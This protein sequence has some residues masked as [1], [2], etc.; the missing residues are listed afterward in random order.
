MDRRAF[1]TTTAGVMAGRLAYGAS[2]RAAHQRTD[3]TRT[4]AGR[5][6]VTVGGRRVRTIDFHAHCLIPGAMELVGEK[7]RTGALI[8]GADRIRVMDE[9]GIDVEVLSINP[10]WYAADAD[11]ARRLIA[12][13]NEKLAELCAASSDRF[14]ALATVAL[15]HPLDA[16]RQLEHA[17][18]RLGLSGGSIGAS[19]N[20]L[21]L[22]SPTFDPFWAKAEELNVPVFIHPQGAPEL[23][24]RLA[25]NGHLANVIGNPL[26][27]TIALSH[28]IFEGTLDRFPGLTLCAAHGGGYLPSYAGRSDAGC[29][30]APDRCTRTIKKRPTDYLKQIV[31]DSLVFTAEGLRHLIAQC[32]VS[33]I[34]LGTDYP[35]PW[36]STAVDHVLGT[37]DLSDADREAILG[38]NAARLLK[39]T[40]TGSR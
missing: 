36:T 40:G 25:G 35:Y 20:G 1:L 38:G 17:V 3:A 18:T 14:V 33:Q 15:Q 23:D 9:Q 19:V 28:L 34:V 11:T 16:A 10:F 31:V 29:T 21:E 27:T 5:R 32:G 30:A 39:L 8:L 26:D 22:S 24:K 6:K 7:T 4:A 2:G 37:P 13:Q 12:M